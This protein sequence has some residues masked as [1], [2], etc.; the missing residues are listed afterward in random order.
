M[1][2]SFPELTRCASGALAVVALISATV[3]PQAQAAGV[4]GQGTWESS[5]QGRD[6]DG[7]QANGFE[8]YFDTALNITWLADA[9]Y[10]RTSGYGE[11]GFLR[12]AD[13]QTWVATLN[14]N[15]VTGW[16]LP[17]L[18]DTGSAGCDWGNSGTDCGYNVSTSSSELAHLYHVTLGNKAHVSTSGEWPQSGWG[19]TNTGPFKNVQSGVYWTG[20]EYAPNA[21]H[22][23]AFATD[24]GYQ[25]NYYRFHS[26]S[27]WAVRSGDVS[28][29][30]VPEP[31]TYALALGGLAAVLVLRRRK[32]A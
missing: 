5:L 2:L 9:N 7:N 25:S 14:V 8:A 3:V 15:G 24:Y 29:P 31:Q 6:L 30:A 1:S 18:V 27:A 12:W 23:W 10:V 19:L 32:Q 28:A 22:A 17:T 4:S 26:F 11:D 16:R 13:A 20:V 21:N